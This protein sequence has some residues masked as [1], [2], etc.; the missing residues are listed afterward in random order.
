LKNAGI[1]VMSKNEKKI[2]I[3]LKRSIIGRPQD[4]KKTVEALGFH[5]LNQV[6]VHTDT[7]QIRGMINKVVHL[8]EVEEVNS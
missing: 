6:V 3:K 2:S 4:Q 1:G 7:P 8:V 5:K